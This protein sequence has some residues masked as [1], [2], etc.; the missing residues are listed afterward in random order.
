MINYQGYVGKATSA[1]Q[2]MNMAE[3]WFS[4]K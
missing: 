1:G 3:A 4:N 2:A